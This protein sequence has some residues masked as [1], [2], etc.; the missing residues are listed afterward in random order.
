MRTTLKIA[1]LV[2]V[3]LLLISVGAF[4]YP[5]MQD[6]FERQYVEPGNVS[7]LEN[8]FYLV[9]SLPNISQELASAT[10]FVDSSNKTVRVYYLHDGKQERLS[11]G[12]PFEEA[13]ISGNLSNPKE[14]GTG[15]G[16]L[17]NATDAVMDSYDA[18]KVAFMVEMNK[19]SLLH[20]Y[21]GTETTEKSYPDM[22]LTYWKPSTSRCAGL[23]VIFFLLFT[24]S[25]LATAIYAVV[26][27]EPTKQDDEK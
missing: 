1:F 17:F 15:W 23:T 25:A 19:S 14:I 8:G 18:G 6:P 13:I 21:T 16:Y 20:P 24:L 7:E 22:S 9:Y 4:V 10:L 2:T 5:L 3:S 11:S 12:K 26:T 27:R